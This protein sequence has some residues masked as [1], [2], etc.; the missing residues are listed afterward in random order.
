MDI[1]HCHKYY[2]NLDIDKLDLFHMD[3]DY[4]THFLDH[5]DSIQC[6]SNLNHKVDLHYSP[7]LDNHNPV[8]YSKNPMDM[9][10]ELMD[11]MNWNMDLY[12]RYNNSMLIID[13]VYDVHEHQQLYKYLI[14]IVMVKRIKS[15]YLQV[16][17]MIKSNMITFNITIALHVEIYV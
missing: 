8:H 7:Y 15:H 13:V 2:L 3:T 17:E 1:I 9:L 16:D 11:H 14:H 5:I 12:L 10:K 4:H 6:H